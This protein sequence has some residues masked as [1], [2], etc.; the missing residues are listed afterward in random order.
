MVILVPLVV[1]VAE[2]LQWLNQAWADSGANVSSYCAYKWDLHKTGTNDQTGSSMWTSA[3]K[4]SATH[5]TSFCVVYVEEIGPI[6]KLSSKGKFN[7]KPKS[8]TRPC[9]A[10]YL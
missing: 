7:G 4:L 3:I 5:E 8:N 10:A 9:T 6:K 1:N 2:D